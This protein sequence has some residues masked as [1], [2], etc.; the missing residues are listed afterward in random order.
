MLSGTLLAA[1]EW[2]RRACS[3]AGLHVYQSHGRRDPLLPFADAEALRELLREAG[4]K[5]DF[6]AFEGQHEIPISVL[7]GLASFVAAR[8]PAAQ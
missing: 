5:V 1:S 3:R 6:H 7:R 8:M 4:L 2:R